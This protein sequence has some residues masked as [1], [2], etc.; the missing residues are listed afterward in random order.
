MLDHESEATALN[1]A[2]LS[3]SVQAKVRATITQLK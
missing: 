1:Y 2:P 3:A